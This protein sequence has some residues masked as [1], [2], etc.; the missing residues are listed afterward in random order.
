M[1]DTPPSGKFLVGFLSDQPEV[2][3]HFGNMTCEWPWP[4]AELPGY[5]RVFAT[6]VVHSMMF[7]PAQFD[8]EQAADLVAGQVAGKIRELMLQGPERS[9]EPP[10]FGPVSNA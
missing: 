8:R 2:Q 6:M 5:E 10:T 7:D 3:D 4:T 9:D 1:A